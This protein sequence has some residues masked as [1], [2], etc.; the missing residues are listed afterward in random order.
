MVILSY[1][2]SNS[3]LKIS[4]L[5]NM[6]LLREMANSRV[7]LTGNNQFLLQVIHLVARFKLLIHQS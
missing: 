1:L 2:P 7:N 6:I 4:G 3:T 5:K